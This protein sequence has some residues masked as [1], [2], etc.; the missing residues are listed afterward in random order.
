[1]ICEYVFDFKRFT[2]HKY[3][4]LIYDKKSITFQYYKY[5][6]LQDEAKNQIINAS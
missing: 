1:M 6:N 4:Q 2:I 3:R 5:T